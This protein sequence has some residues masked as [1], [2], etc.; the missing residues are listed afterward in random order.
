MRPNRAAGFTLLELLVVV[1][2]IAVLA[3]L[4]VPSLTGSG[5][6]SLE[7]SART[8]VDLL[9]RARQEAAL[10]ARPWCVTL[11]PKERSY[12]FQRRTGGECR[13][14]EE[15]LFRERHLPD[16]VRWAKAV[17]GGEP[18]QGTGQALLFPTGEQDPMGVVLTTAN[19][20]QRR[21][22]RL[23]PVGR[24]RVTDGR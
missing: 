6:R 19:G 11:R 1:A 22:V 9:N 7:R 4:L 23:G 17:I 24:A 20:E 2:V 5:G 15:K 13:Q 3:G 18:V 14:V 8:L 12:A 16:G 10:E 21:R